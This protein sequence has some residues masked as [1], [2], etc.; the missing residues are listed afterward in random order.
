M[1]WWQA[2][3]LGL[4]QGLTEFL[5]VS[6]SGHLT[7]LH[8]V[9]GINIGGAELFFNIILH[10]GTL[11]AVCIIFWRDILDLFKKPFKTLLYLVVA[12][13]P[14]GVAG[15]LLDDIIE[16][17][18]MGGKF[19][20]AYLAAFFALTAAVLFATEVFAKRRKRVLPLCFR[21]TVP[22]GFAQAVAI[23]PGVSRSGSTIAAGTFAGGTAEEVSK[24]S[25]LMSIPVI[26]GSFSVELVKGLV[27]EGEKGFAYSFGVAGPQFGWC[28][29]IGF[30]ISAAAGLFAIKIMLAAIK[31]AN[32]KW[33]SLYLVL[34]AIACTVLQCLGKF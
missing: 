32:Y 19:A 16:E 11:V 34:L 23:L 10:L 9:L 29:A 4:T 30:I 22:M 17:H 31:K 3:V 24:F 6:S 15:L 14:A 12:T 26:L 20:G 2:L 7:F 5:P 18:M 27:G 33:F 25:F 8:R 21:T 13:I 1:Q 28:I